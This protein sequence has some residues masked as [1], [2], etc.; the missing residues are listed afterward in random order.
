MSL[1][2]TLK[3]YEKVIIGGA[4]IRNGNRTT[5]LAVDNNVPVLRQKD[6]MS[7][8]QADSPCRRIYFAIQLMYIDEKNLIV[9]HNSYWKLVRDLVE[10]APSFLGLVDEISEQ[11]LKTNFYQALKLARKLMDYEQE[12]LHLVQ[13]PNANV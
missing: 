7:E 13:E 2:V 5:N 12:V 8:K 11:I 9:H 4:V 6:I 10:A 3:P 1:K